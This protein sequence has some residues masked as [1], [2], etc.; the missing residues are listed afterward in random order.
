MGSSSKRAR[1][2]QK[3]QESLEREASHSNPVKRPQ[4]DSDPEEEEDHE[5]LFPPR[6]RETGHAIIARESS[7]SSGLWCDHYGE[8]TK[9]RYRCGVPRHYPD[10]ASLP[11]AVHG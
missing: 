7:G 11:P 1:R 6:K 8:N 4:P 5:I 3:A 10:T 2:R 9:R